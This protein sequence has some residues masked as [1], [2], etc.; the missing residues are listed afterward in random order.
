MSE[1]SIPLID[2][3]AAIEIARQ[4]MIQINQ[5]SPS[6][7]KED[8]FEQSIKIEDPWF[9]GTVLLETRSP[10]SEKDNPYYV[11]YAYSIYPKMYL[12]I[13]AMTG[14]VIGE[15][16]MPPYNKENIRFHIDAITD[17]IVWET[18]PPPHNDE[19]VP[20]PQNNKTGDFYSVL[21]R[22]FRRIL[23]MPEEKQVEQIEPP[24]P[25]IGHEA[26]IEIARKHAIQKGWG[27]KDL[28]MTFW[29]DRP[30]E[31]EYR[32]YAIGL[33]PQCRW[34]NWYDSFL[35]DG[36]TG[37]IFENLPVKEK[38][39]TNIPLIGCEAAIE[40]ARQ[41]AMQKGWREDDLQNTACLNEPLNIS[42]DGQLI[43]YI[44][45]TNTERLGDGLYFHIDAITGEILLER[46]PVCVN[47]N[48]PQGT[49]FIGSEAAIEIARQRVIQKN[50]IERLRQFCCQEPFR[51]SRRPYYVINTLPRGIHGFIGPCFYVD[52]ITGEILSEY[53][54]ADVLRRLSCRG[55]Y[56]NHYD[57]VTMN[58][59]IMINSQR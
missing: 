29:I 56:M 26:A 25:L 39:E 27:K 47:K 34:Y 14:R 54:S 2:R 43:Y 28:E 20:L 45:N 18:E 33:F 53:P 23:L 40:I 17:K 51:R 32:F 12:K 8:D 59:R 44:V 58:R 52:A 13:D 4:H 3:K 1:N 38:I 16:I 55:L 5:T 22:F 30:P 24:I 49:D 48:R 37:D 46:P 36:E 42:I 41:R 7:I 31:H 57:D 6:K 9:V 21:H 10:S 50:R 35:I 11:V 15:K 19:Y